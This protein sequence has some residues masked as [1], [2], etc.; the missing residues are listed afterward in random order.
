MQGIY[1]Y[2]ITASDQHLDIGPIGLPDGQSTVVSLQEQGV[3]AMVSEYEGLAFD[4]LAKAQVLR[5]LT[6]H[7]RVI[8][9]A[10]TRHTV[11]PV[12][13]GT[14]LD[15][16]DEVA[17]LLTRW[18]EPLVAT[19][20]QLSDAIEVEVAATWDLPQTFAAIARQPKIASLAASIAN[21]PAEETMVQRVQIGQLVK[22]AMDLR[23]GNYFQQTIRK[24]MPLAQDVQPN[25]LLSEELVL[26]VAFLVRR[27]ELDAFYAGINDLDRMLEGRLT[28]RCIGPLPPYSF[29]TVDIIKPRHAE[30]EAARHRLELGEWASANDLVANYR[31]LA[32]RYHPDC[33]PGDRKAT[34]RFAALAKAYTQ[35]QAYIS[36]QDGGGADADRRYHLGLAATMAIP[37]LNIRRSGV[38]PTPDEEGAREYQ[39]VAV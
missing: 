39:L 5:C 6:I 2:A 22:E 18:K 25:P 9:G 28:F 16:R 27:A 12:K 35:L 11:L 14:V 4:T 34:E 3:A 8:E 21:M 17:A 23:R 36:S 32:R 19:L 13:F 10:M 37:A 31:R 30:I 38:L 26:N 15:S 24:L 33:N 20:E 1:L 7:Q 29:A